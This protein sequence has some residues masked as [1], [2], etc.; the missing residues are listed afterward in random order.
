M[1]AILE[2]EATSPNASSSFSI[3]SSRQELNSSS[4]NATS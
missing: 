2:K 3:H 1:Q 4:S